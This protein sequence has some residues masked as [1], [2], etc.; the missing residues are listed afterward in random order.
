MMRLNLDFSVGQRSYDILSEGFSLNRCVGASG[1]HAVQKVSL[2]IRSEEASR[3][4]LTE[5]KT[6]VSASVTDGERMIFEGVVRPYRTFTAYGSKEGDLSLEVLDWTEALDVSSSGETYQDRSI[7]DIV[8]DILE[9]VGI[10]LEVEGGDAVIDFAALESDETYSSFL[11]TLCYEHGLDFVFTPGKVSLVSTV[12]PDGVLPEVPSLIGT[13]SVSRS[14]AKSDGAEVTYPVLCSR[15][16]VMLYSQTVRFDGN[17]RV[18]PSGRRTG[19]MYDMAMHD[20]EETPSDGNGRILWS[21][22]SIAALEGCDASDI[23]IVGVDNVEMVSS[24][25]DEWGVSVEGHI[26]DADPKGARVWV[27]YSGTFNYILG[28]GW[29]FTSSVKAD[30]LYI[31]RQTGAVVTSEGDKVE[32]VDLRTVFTSDEAQ[33]FARVLV[34]RQKASGVTYSFQSDRP[35]KVGGFFRLTENRVTGIA[36]DIRVLSCTYDYRTGLSSVRAEGASEVEEVPVA[37]TGIASA[38]EAEP[39]FAIIEDDEVL[40]VHGLEGA[41]FR[42]EQ[43]GR[44][45]GEGREVSSAGLYG[46]VECAALVDGDEVKRTSKRLKAQRPSARFLGFEP[47]GLENPT[48][49]GDFYLSANGDIREWDGSSFVTV[50]DPSAS[51]IFAALPYAKDLQGGSAV[52]WMQTIATSKAFIDYLVVNEANVRGKLEA[53]SVRAEGVLETQFSSSGASADAV[54]PKVIARGTDLAGSI[55]GSGLRPASVRVDGIQYTQ[56]CSVSDE[57]VNSSLDY[58]YTFNANVGWRSMSWRHKVSELAL[59]Q[60]GNAEGVTVHSTLNI[61]AD[62]LVYLELV[63]TGG[64]K[65]TDISVCVYDAQDETHTVRYIYDKGTATV[66]LWVRGS[67]YVDI[68][69][70]NRYLLGR[71]TLKYTLRV[72]RAK[73][74]GG[75]CLGVTPFI[76]GI[77]SQGSTEG[78]QYR[79][80]GTF[81]TPAGCKAIDVQAY[82]STGSYSIPGAIRISTDRYEVTEN[83]QY[84]IRIPLWKYDTDGVKEAVTTEINALNIAFQP[85]TSTEVQTF[86]TDGSRSILLQGADALWQHDIESSASTLVSGRQIV[87]YLESLNLAEGRFYDLS[88][89]T[90]VL[91]SEVLHPTRLILGTGSVQ[92]VT[93]S[94]VRSVRESDVFTDA[95]LSF[96]VLASQ[97]AVKVASIVPMTSTS[98]VGT[99]DNPMYEVHGR[100]VWGAVFN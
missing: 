36:S 68:L 87:S 21:V 31:R 35:L 43:D 71:K 99:Q 13:L 38:S 33:E 3:L 73:G 89:A 7:S 76:T 56:G 78:S 6:L 24:V 41:D 52:E 85:S 10:D 20:G 46:E 12:R 51:Q 92:F 39:R 82:V 58:Q 14:D 50:T 55:G 16:S 22:Q 17:R 59:G 29:G 15:A 84:E 54:L 80:V 42:W 95:A 86:L 28:V 67:E 27:S 88:D 79:T 65:A 19:I 47:E 63:K 32:K 1:R 81:T 66:G 62:E 83:T 49:A 23:S 96:T 69:S 45:L 11:S 53:S 100:W 25:T 90:V 91:G 74:F 97:N 75:V 64:D 8:G 9:T 30:V 2:R 40:S 70:R 98:S 93:V 44:V 72:Y 61:G 94:D 77:E 18:E 5:P 34:S 60:H 26:S 4:F 37:D 48:M 57:D